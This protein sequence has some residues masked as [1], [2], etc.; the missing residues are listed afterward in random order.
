MNS[1]N[2]LLTLAILL[3]GCTWVPLDKSADG[4]Q[5]AT[6]AEVEKCHRLGKVSTKVAYKV[7]G[8]ERSEKKVATELATLARNEA[9]QMQGDTIAPE[10]EIVTGRQTFGIYRCN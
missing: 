6:A 5:L 8:I 3:G 7:A 10:S 4:V 9:A 2:L 1:R